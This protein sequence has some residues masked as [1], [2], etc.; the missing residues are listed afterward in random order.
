MEALLWITAGL[1]LLMACLLYPF[2]GL[3]A[4]FTG[5]SQEIRNNP[6]AMKCI[7]ATSMIFGLSAVFL[8]VSY[9]ALQEYGYIQIRDVLVY[10]FPFYTMP[11]I[12]S[13]ANRLG[14]L[15]EKASGKD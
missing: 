12:L 6:K 11:P 10:T 7:G 4:G 5:R 1:Y 3:L 14:R 13:Q 15:L 2:P 8:L 9:Y